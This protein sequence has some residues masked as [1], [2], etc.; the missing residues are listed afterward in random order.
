MTFVFIRYSIR[1]VHLHNI[2]SLMLLCKVDLAE[3]HEFWTRLW[4][5]FFPS[6][7]KKEGRRKGE[8]ISKNRDKRSC[9]S[10]RSVKFKFQAIKIWLTQIFYNAIL[11][12]NNLWLVSRK[13]LKLNNYKYIFKWFTLY[14][15]LLL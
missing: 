13:M 2:K 7:L 3:R 6:L 11:I 12:N 1:N 8:W 5:L 14:I 4:I 15:F 10:A 9:L